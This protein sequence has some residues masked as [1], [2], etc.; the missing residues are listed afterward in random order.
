MEMA[1]TVS[2][3]GLAGQLKL[4]NFS[5]TLV[6]CCREY[7]KAWFR[8]RYWFVPIVPLVKT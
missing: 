6:D 5:M 7:G 1:T 3:D 2:T 4:P 8:R